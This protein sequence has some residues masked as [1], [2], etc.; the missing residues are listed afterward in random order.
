ME[1]DSAV[2]VSHVTNKDGGGSGST[3]I[4]GGG[5]GAVR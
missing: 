5:S 3:R 4:G 1:H 2:I